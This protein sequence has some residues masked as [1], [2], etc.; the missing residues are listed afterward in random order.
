MQHYYPNK[1]APG[2]QQKILK[3]LLDNPGTELPD[4][5]RIEGENLLDSL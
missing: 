2:R 5:L 3:E 1:N 4:H